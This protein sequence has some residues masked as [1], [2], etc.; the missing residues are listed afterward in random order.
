M[1]RIPLLQTL[2]AALAL[3]ASAVQAE[4]QTF[5]AGRELADRLLHNVVAISVA[6]TKGSGFA[7]GSDDATVD[8]VT[9]LHTLAI[10][11]DGAAAPPITITFCADAAQVQPG[12]DAVIWMNR[13]ADLAVVR[14]PRPSDYLP[15]LAAIDDAHATTGEPVWSAGKDGA[16]KIGDGNGAIDVPEDQYRNLQADLPGAYG[17]T[18]GSPLLTER[19]I[20]G[21][22]WSS[23]S[24]VK[25]TAR[26]I[27][28]IREL[29]TAAPGVRWSLLPARNFAPGTRGAAAT[30]LSRVLNNYAFNVKNMRD[31][32]LA[33]TYR[34]PELAQIFRQYND[35]IR[36]FNATKDKYDG[37]LDR[38]W[39]AATRVDYGALRARVESVHAVILSINSKMDAL[40]GGNTVPREI[41][42]R[43]KGINGE[44]DALDRDIQAF[45]TL[46]RR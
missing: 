5:L 16:C 1:V 38:H 32:L 19:G 2:S 27:A 43:M 14:V 24:N 46:L 11:R 34:T 44:V 39:G 45:V 15:R 26:S 42:N 22:V 8:V 7:I 35:A 21:L 31:A 20:A 13:A 9:A 3:A 10:P 40:R 37:S 25:V 6:G 29:L 36:D 12:A 28:H 18:S 30:E 17:G 4:E 33:K 23:A 41:R